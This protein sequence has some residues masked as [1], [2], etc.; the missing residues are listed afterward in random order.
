MFIRYGI[1]LSLQAS[2]TKYHR[3]NSKQRERERRKGGRW[4]K[5]GGGK[6]K[7]NGG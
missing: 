4:K 7:K 1:S 2:I 6:R 3:L 5:E